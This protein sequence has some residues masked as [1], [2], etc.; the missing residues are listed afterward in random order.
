MKIKQMRFMTRREWVAK[1]YTE[2]VGKTYVGGVQFCPHYYP[3]TDGGW[4]L[5]IRQEERKAKS[6]VKCWSQPAVIDGKYILVRK[7]D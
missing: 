5:A 1:N 3:F 2:R 6:C 4:C 7:E